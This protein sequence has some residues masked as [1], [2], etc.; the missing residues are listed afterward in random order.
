MTELLKI[1]VV[2]ALRDRQELKTLAVAK[3][4]T[5]AAA[6]ERSKLYDE[7]PGEGLQALP[8]G[9]WGRPADRADLVRDGDRIE[10]YRPLAMDPRDARRMLA[11]SG[12]TMNQQRNGT[13]PK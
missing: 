2:F 10:L 13:L 1:E 8:V 4:T 3:G 6:L 5:I 12:R 7:F 9:I 11:E